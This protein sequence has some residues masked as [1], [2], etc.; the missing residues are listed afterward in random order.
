MERYVCSLIEE[1]RRFV[2]VFLTYLACTF[3]KR[4]HSISNI[5]TDQVMILRRI[6][7]VCCENF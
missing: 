5:E 3:D 7:A 4:T 2:T 1:E 6:I